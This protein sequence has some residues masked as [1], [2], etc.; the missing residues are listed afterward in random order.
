MGP[1][2]GRS[3]TGPDPTL[4]SFPSRHQSAQTNTD[5]FFNVSFMQPTDLHP[6]LRIE[7]RGSRRPPLPSCALHTFITLSSPLFLDKYQL[8]S[9]NFLASNNLRSLHSVYGET[10]LEAPNWTVKSWGS[11]YLLELD[12]SHLP[13]TYA[14]SELD[15]HA[16]IP[17]HLRYL[18]PY[19]GVESREADSET[20]V[21]VAWPALF[22]ACPADSDSRMSTNPFDRTNLGYDAFFGPRT[23]FHHLQPLSEG[24]LSVN[25]V[26]PSLPLASK[27]WVESGTFASVALGFMWVC[28]QLMLITRRGSVLAKIDRHPKTD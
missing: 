25:L 19:E 1:Y 27:F 4:F 18:L 5:G 13:R 3:L 2:S 28:F 26:A 11:A 7:I 9:P 23:T 20:P 10:D 12:T 16:N 24:L 6:T 14:N 21:R 8:S 15:W 22:W 17:L